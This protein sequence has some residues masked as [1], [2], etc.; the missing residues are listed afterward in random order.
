MKALILTA[1]LTLLAGCAGMGGYGSGDMG[2]RG[3]TGS[4]SDYYQ[5]RDDIFNSWVS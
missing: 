4:E 3:A 2:N 1:V 5:Q